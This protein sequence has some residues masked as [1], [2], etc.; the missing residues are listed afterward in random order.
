MSIEARALCKAW[1]GKLA[2]DHVSFVVAAGEVYGLI[3][4]N[5]AGKTTTQRMLAGLLAP[6]AG[7]ALVAGI[8]ISADP[9][10]GKREL[11]FDLGAV[12]GGRPKGLSGHGRLWTGPM[13]DSLVSP[14]C[15]MDGGCVGTWHRMPLVA[16]HVMFSSHKVLTV[17]DEQMPI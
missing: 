8:D 4:P 14:L 12:R 13:D 3:G 6:G 9:V 2:V 16:G 1:D 17:L 10:R 11:E 15:A 7:Q 5:G